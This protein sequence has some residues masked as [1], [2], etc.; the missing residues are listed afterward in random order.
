MTIIFIILGII[1][2]VGLI[3][4]LRYFIP[5]RPKE[6]GFE[7]VYVNEDGTVSELDEKDVE[8]L[9]TEFSPADGARPYIK[10]HYKELTPDRKISGFILRYRVPKKIEIK[11]L[12]NP[13]DYRH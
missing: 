4:Y 3:V 12:K 2:I 5:L 1:A 10:N 9:K 7:Y 8:Y 13:Q 6:P 11:P